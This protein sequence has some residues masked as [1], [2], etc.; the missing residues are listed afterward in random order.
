VGAFNSC[1]VSNFMTIISAKKLSES[2]QFWLRMWTV[3]LL[4][5]P[6]DTWKQYDADINK[7]DT[8]LKWK[9]DTT[10]ACR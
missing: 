4:H 10:D 6:V 2:V 9:T 1:S 3:C 5:H 7:D 8:S